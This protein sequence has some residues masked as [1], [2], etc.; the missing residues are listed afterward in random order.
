[1]KYLISTILFVFSVS[2]FAQTTYPGSISAAYQLGGSY[3]KTCR[4]AKVGATTAATVYSN[5]SAYCDED[6]PNF[7]QINFYS[8]TL[9][10]GDPWFL[11]VSNDDGD[12]KCPGQTTFHQTAYTLI[13][14]VAGSYYKTCT[15]AYLTATHVDAGIYV[16]AVLQANCGGI[17][18]ILPIY[19]NCSQN[20]HGFYE[21]SNHDGQL[22]CSD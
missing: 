18:S 13:N 6:D 4:A 11:K 8:C 3:Y 14:P 19:G 12:L 7:S 22:V 20:S 9:P 2:S 15:D 21:V 10:S 1:M 16:P 5:L 17:T